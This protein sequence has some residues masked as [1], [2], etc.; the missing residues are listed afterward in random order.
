LSK[1]AFSVSSNDQLGQFDKVFMLRAI[2]SHLQTFGSTIV[3]GQS[4]ERVNLMVSSLGM[5][6]SPEER[7]SSRYAVEKQEAQYQDDYD[8]DLFVQGLLK[9]ES[10]TFWLPI[11]DVVTSLYPSTLIDVDTLEVQQT[12]LYHEHCIKRKEFLDDMLAL[13]WEDQEETPEYPIMG[14]FHDVQDIGPFVQTFMNDL[15]L[16]PGVDDVR[17]SFLSSFLRVLDRKA[18]ALIKYVEAKSSKGAKPLDNTAKRQLRHD[19]QLTTEADF[20]IVLVR[21]EKHQQGMYVFFMGDPR[22]SVARVQAI[23][24]SL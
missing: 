13:I 1:T 14:L 10:G 5:F 4:I 24:E 20:L 21:A 23:L 12:C 17:Q 2:T 7:C 9:D 6:L 11:K 3:I 19:L 15:S 22:Q 18:L 8:P 16:L